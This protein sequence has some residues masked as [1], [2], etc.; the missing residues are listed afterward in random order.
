MD[1]PLVE[2]TLVPHAK[3]DLWGAAFRLEFSKEN[4]DVNNNERFESKQFSGTCPTGMIQ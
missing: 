3:S 2:I 4:S 1:F